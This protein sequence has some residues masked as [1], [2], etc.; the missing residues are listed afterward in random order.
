[1]EARQ[2]DLHEYHAARNSSNENFFASKLWC[3]VHRENIMP[4]G[5]FTKG[6]IIGTLLLFKYKKLGKTFVIHP[7]LSPHCGLHV[8]CTAEKISTQQTQ[9][10]RALKALAAFLADYYRDAYI[11]FCLPKEIIDAQPFQWAGFSASPRFSYRL[12]L[13]LSSDALLD[14]MTTERRKNIRKGLEQN[15]RV[16]QNGNAEDLI[17]LLAQTAS[18]GGYTFQKDLI[19]QLI[20]SHDSSV[21]YTVVYLAEK[22]LAAAMCGH[23]EKCAYYLSGGHDATSGDHLAGA[24][25]LWNIISETK[26]IGCKEFDFLGSSVPDIEKY[27]RGF[28]P[29][30]ISYTRIMR[31]RGIRAWLK[32]QKDKAK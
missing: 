7:P 26:K 20:D 24:F 31:N 32:R 16:E 5:I 27:F 3:N 21:F 2:I 9:I 15:Y 4:V 8:N 17:G 29:E 22:P 25:C 19:T 11:D 12:N 10:K 14:Q 28:G 23:D 6:G 18:R 1:M 30:L 13:Q